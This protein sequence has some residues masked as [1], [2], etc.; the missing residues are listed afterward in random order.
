VIVDTTSMLERRCR[1]RWYPLRD[2]AVQLAYVHDPVRFKLAPCGRRSGKTERAK[3]KLV[4]AAWR[5]PGKPFFAGAPTYGQAKKIWWEDLKLLSFAPLMG[6]RSV[7]EGELIIRFPNQASIHVLGLDQPARVEGIPWGGGVVDE[8]A[9]CHA[10]AVPMHILPSLSTVDPRDP[11][12]R[13]W[14]DLIGVP[15]GLNHYYKLCEQARTGQWPDA[16]VY[17]WISADILP[18]DEIEARRGTMSL[19]Q[20]RQEYEASF[21]GAT[22]RIYADYGDKNTTAERIQPNEAL[23]WMHDFNYTPLSSAIAVE[24]AGKLYALDEIVLTSAVAHNTAV[25]F[26]ERYKTHGNRVIRLYGDP[27][28]RAGEKHAQQSNYTAIESYLRSQGWTVDR[29]VKLAAPAIRDRQNA[30][31]AKICNARGERTLFVNPRTCPTLHDGLSTVQLKEGSAFQEDDS[32]SAQHITTALGY[33]IDREWPVLIDSAAP[34]RI[35][36][37]VPSASPWRRP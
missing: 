29:R 28:G 10:D 16:R 7:S 3:R 27:A 25:E 35:V 2:H 9:D 32:N 30:V 17:H 4:K 31:R 13:A 11:E 15:E 37:P 33:W 18:A 6:P 1:E 23:A 14:L 24:R 21:E 36:T 8:I 26:C 22:G 5:T 12:Y 19:Q 20:F 34:K